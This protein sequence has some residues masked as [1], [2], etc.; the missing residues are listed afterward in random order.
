MAPGGL[1]INYAR[2]EPG[3]RELVFDACRGMAQIEKPGR[4]LA[5]FEKAPQPA[6][7][8]RG[9]GEVGLAF[10]RPNEKDRRRLRQRFE[11]RI[12]EREVG[13]FKA[14]NARSS[15]R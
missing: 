3:S 9:P 7:Q 12:E 1:I 13:N 5:L 10:A 2:F 8:P 11:G 14:L 15:Y 4:R 6:P